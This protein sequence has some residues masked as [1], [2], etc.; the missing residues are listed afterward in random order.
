MKILNALVKTTSDERRYGFSQWI[1]EY[2][3]FGG[4][5]YPLGVQTTYGYDKAEPI[6]DNFAGHVL[7]AYQ[8]NGVISAVELVRFSIFSE[9]RFRYQEIN[10][11]GQGSPADAGLALFERPWPGGTTGDLLARMILDA[12]LAGNAYITELDGEL[13]RL[14]PDWVEIVLAERRAFVGPNSEAVTVGLR[15]AGYYYYEG[16]RANAKIPAFFL[17]NEVA[18]FAPM[19]DPLATYRGMSWLTPIVREIQSDTQATKHKLKFFENA[20]TPN[21]AVKLPKELTP[22]QFTEFVDLMDKRHKGVDNAYETLYTAGGADVTVIGADMHQLDFKLT[23]GAG[24]TRIAAAG[25]IHPVIVGLSEGMQGASLNAGNFAAAR[26]RV[27]DGTMRPLWRNVC[28][29]LEVLITPPPGERLWYD[30]AGIGFLREDARDVA[31]I[32]SRQMLTIES[33]VRAGFKPDAVVLATSGE[34]VRLLLGEHTGLFSVQLQPPQEG[35][36]AESDAGPPAE[37]P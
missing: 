23:Q 10:G 26:R 3:N 14:R 2:F 19:P 18:H 13:V 37:G 32:L 9:A 27:G 4:S 7:N 1:S 31:E 16:G 33:G 6:G 29:S 30:A 21:L 36:G 25:G 17:P 35:D 15:R 12:D 5:R 22:K 11:R 20:A 28:G 8:A 34:D 24:E